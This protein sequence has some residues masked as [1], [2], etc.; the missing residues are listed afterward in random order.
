MQKNCLKRRQG[1]L[2]C[3]SKNGLMIEQLHDQRERL[4]RSVKVKELQNEKCQSR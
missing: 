2:S 4:V 1:E 3:E